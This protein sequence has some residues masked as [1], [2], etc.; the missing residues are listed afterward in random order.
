MKWLGSLG[1]RA[2]L[3]KPELLALWLVVLFWGPFCSVKSDNF[4]AFSEFKN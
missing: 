4:M 3:L 2:E 1:L